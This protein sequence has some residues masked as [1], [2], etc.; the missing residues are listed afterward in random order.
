MI[1]LLD[2]YV[3]RLAKICGVN[4]FVFVTRSEMVSERTARS[5]GHEI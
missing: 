3:S 2:S 5:W 4:K 1:S